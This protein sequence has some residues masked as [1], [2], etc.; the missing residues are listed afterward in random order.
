MPNAGRLYDMHGN[1][2]EWCEYWYGPYPGE[3]A[4][5]PRGSAA[6]SLRVLRNGFCDDTAS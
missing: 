2:E 4:M 1:L 6:G 5:D 3:S